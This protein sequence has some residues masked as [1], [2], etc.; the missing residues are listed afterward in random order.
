L[1]T[2]IRIEDGEGATRDVQSNIILAGSAAAVAR[3]M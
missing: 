2:S 3:A 1:V